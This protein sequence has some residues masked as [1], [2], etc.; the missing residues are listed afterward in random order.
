MIRRSSEMK[1]EVR[2]K[3]RGGDGAITF[4]H[5]FD[6][7]EMGAKTRLCTKLT[8]PPGASI[9]THQHDNEDEVFLILSGSGVIDDGKTKTKVSAGDA[10]LTKNGES[11]SVRNDG[12]VPL[13]IAALIMCY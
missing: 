12:N 9:G 8:L 6:K 7:T 13:E 1:V 2:E 3:M 4:Q 5:Y 10:T 11:H